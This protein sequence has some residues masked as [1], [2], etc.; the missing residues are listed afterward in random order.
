[1]TAVDD[2]A[3]AAG[4]ARSADAPISTDASAATPAVTRPQRG[5][6]LPLLLRLHFLAGILVGPF[7]LTAALSG[8]AYALAPTAEQIV[9]ADELHAPA[10]GSTV[11]LAQQVEAAEAVVGGSGT[12]VAVR[13]APAPG[14]T[15]RVMFTGDGLIPSQTRAIFVDPADASIRGDLPVYGTSG[16]LPLRTAISHFHRT[17]GLGDPGRLYSELAASW[18]GIVTLAG[19]GLWVARWRRSP[20]KR[21]L[22]RPD[23]RATGYRRILSWHASTGVWLV[24]GALFLSA[25]GITWSQFGGQNVT[26]LRAALSW[27]A[28]TLTTALPG[29]GAGAASAA[30]PHVGHH[31]SAAPTT[32]P[33]V[34]PATFDDVLRVARGV[35][36]NTGLVEITPPK[37]ASTAWTVSEIQRSF[38]T[39]VDQVAVDGSTLQVVG[40][41]DFADYPLPAK[42]A[43]WGIDTHQGSMFG[44]PNQLLLAVT[45]LGIAAMVVF[46]YLMWWKRRPGVARPGRPAPAGALVR[47]PWWGIAAV[48]AVG[49]GV[50][51]FLPL[52]GI[53][54]VG[55]VLL[56]ALIT[57]ARVHRAGAPA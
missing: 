12:L 26:D 42:L 55:F 44:L 48:V 21:D 50:G 5:W 16:A 2:R 51:L 13:P 36:V 41:T 49:V 40:R 10:T 18:L 7:I 19:L 43:R 33:A 35:N 8:A 54:L 29:A 11:P 20:R 31:A 32:T 3:A 23:A 14:D 22:V 38:P 6:F 34:D 15:T 1:M 47:A 45:A 9:Y 24:A 17:L 28:P 39:E 52:V 56:D 57:A 4:P 37:D 30:D 27:Q 46:G 53:P 25:T